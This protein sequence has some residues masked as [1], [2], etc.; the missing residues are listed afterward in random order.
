MS[1]GGGGRRKTRTV[2]MPAPA[3]P[4]QQ[5]NSMAAMLAY[6]QSSEARADARAAAEKAER[7]A[8]EAARKAAG[9]QGLP[10]F[11]SL[12]QSQ[13]QSGLI[14]ELD[15]FSR[16]KD[17]G[18]R[19]DLDPSAQIQAEKAVG[20]Y[21]SQQLQPQR[22]VGGVERLYQDLLGREMTDEERE[23]YFQPVEADATGGYKGYSGLQQA[24]VTEGLSGIRS[25]IM[26]DEE[27]KNKMNDSYL[28]NY[29]DTVFGKQTRDEKNA[30]TKKRTF[31]FN[32]ELLP[33]YADLA[34]LQEQT[35]IKLPNYENYFGEARSVKELEE[36]IQGIRDTRQYLYSTGLTNLQGEID[37]D[38]QKIKSKADVKKQ[39]IGSQG[40][41]LQ[42]IAGAFSF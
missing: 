38:L 15:A 3:P 39:Q 28:E 37:K 33:G 18:S 30:G 8:K 42:Q 32:Q 4:V 26:S 9:A 20:E 11:Q 5:D 31:A 2:Y 27:Y 29:Y 12:L 1:S 14:T 19:Y 17:Y 6:I 25:S 34:G 16:L 35:G 7:E 10:D 22:L 36:G 23:R 40:G 13:L 21:F 41:V 24:F